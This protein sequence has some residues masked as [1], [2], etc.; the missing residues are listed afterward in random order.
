MVRIPLDNLT[1]TLLLLASSSA[2]LPVSVIS[3]VPVLIV[4]AEISTPLRL[5]EFVA[6]PELFAVKVTSPLFDVIFAA[7]IIP[8]PAVSVKES[9]AVA[10]AMAAFTS[11]VPAPPLAA[12][13]NVTESLN[14]S[15]EAMSIAPVPVADPILIALWPLVNRE[16]TSA[17]V[18]IKPVPI[19]PVPIP[20]LSESLIALMLSAPV[21]PKLKVGRFWPIRVRSPV[22]GD[23]VVELP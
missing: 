18:I 2:A 7:V 1:P 4:E 19:A 3:P 15:A 11:I 23:S 21:P 12:D 6:V 14:V 20:I 8:L 16:L 17:A 9:A 22:P 5:P 10:I 13:C